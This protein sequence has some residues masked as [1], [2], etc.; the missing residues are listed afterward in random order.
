MDSVHRFAGRPTVALV[1]SGGGAKG[2]AEVGVLRYIEEQKI[3]V[4]LVLGTSIGGLVGA[5]YSLGY[6]ADEIQYLFQN[7]DW[8]MILS[9]V[10]DNRY[11]CYERKRYNDRYLISIPFHYEKRSHKSGDTDSGQYTSSDGLLHI[12]ASDEEAREKVVN[13]SFA[14]SLPSGIAYGFNVNNLISSLTVGYQDSISFADLPIPFACVAADVVSCKAKN[15]GSGSLKTAMRSTMSI[16]GLFNPVRTEGMILVDGGTRNNF[17][18]DLAKAMGADYIIG[19]DLSDI[20]PDYTQ[21]NNIG[22]VLMQFIT[23][24]GKDAFNKNVVTPDVFVKP[25]ISEYNM[26]S[27]SDDAVETMLRRG[28]EAARREADAFAELKAI[29][30]PSTGALSNTKAVD[31]SKTPVRLEAIVFEGVDDNESRMMM[32]M[33][34]LDVSETIDRERIDDAMSKLQATGLFDAVTYSLTGSGEPYRLVFHCTPAPVHRLGMGLRADT[35]DW[36]SLLFNVGLNVNKMM[37]STLNIEGR[38]GQSQSLVARYSYGSMNLPMVNAELSLGH[39][40]G[41]LSGIYDNKVNEYVSYLSHSES[42]FIS[43]R[44]WARADVK[45][46]LRN[47]GFVLPVDSHF[48]N[49][50]DQLSSSMLRGDYVGP[51]F[52]VN[53]YTMDD[54]YFPT[55]GLDLKVDASYDVWKPGSKGFVPIFTSGLNLRFVIPFG[56]GFAIIPDLDLRSVVDHNSMDNYSISHRNTIGG[57]IRGRYLDQQIPFLGINNTYLVSYDHLAV[58]SIDFRIKMAEDFFLTATGSVMRDSDNF[59][60]LVDPRQGELHFGTAIQIGYN[61]IFGPL[62]ANVHWSDISRSFG[63]YLSLGFDF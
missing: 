28:Y 37:G 49:Q 26:M 41:R 25:S 2:A 19:V 58:A 53:V 43:S 34:D 23:M 33:V 59:I 44:D 4:D 62:K 46:G 22:D 55:H 48:G 1:L 20:D 8:N 56:T 27:F 6:N 5:L 16:P 7:Q 35:E 61:S 21:V 15:W 42:V 17:P 57:A 54:A 47:R 12:G 63:A 32:E 9:D 45:L 10:V 18:T 30:G 24:L 38:L 36:A 11:Y 13:N 52:N 14:S 60:G 29:T 3:P 31:V 50:L 39:Y 51:F 40:R